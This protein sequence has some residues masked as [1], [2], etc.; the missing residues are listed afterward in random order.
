MNTRSLQRIIPSIPASDGAGVKLMR[1][2]G[3][4]AFQRVDPFLMLDEISSDNPDDYLAGFP[5]HPHRGFETVT[6]LLEGHM[7]HEDHLGNRGNLRSGGV[8][9][10]TA[11]RGIIHSEI[12]QQEN[13]RLHGFQLWINLPAAE[14]MKP[15]AYR[16]IQ[17][18]EIPAVE[19]AGGGVARVIAGTLDTDG[20]IVQGPVQGLSTAPL[21]LDVRLPPKGF[22]SHPVA[23]RHSAFIYPY[24]G[25]LV[26]GVAET[27][28]PLLAHEAGVLS[29]GEHI[30]LSAGA[31]GAGFLLLAASPL[32]EPIVQWGPFVMN[33]RE[34]ID[35]AIRDYENDELV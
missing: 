30:E 13:G 3:Q 28:L 4:T 33:T 6:Y 24:Q 1:S 32:Q 31:D 9:W 34:E 10:M 2:L 23:T 19:L 15:A 26:I 14:K 20:R 8:Q 21:F 35:Q 25:S 16:D 22:F 7:L 12:P 18:E 29:S 11:G 5:S 27:A 17:T